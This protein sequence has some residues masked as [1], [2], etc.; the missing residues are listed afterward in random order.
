MIL[1]NPTK[2]KQVTA[3]EQS[4]KLRIDKYPYVSS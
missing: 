1:Y 4:E 2:E 3:K